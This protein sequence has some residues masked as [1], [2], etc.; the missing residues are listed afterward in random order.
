MHTIVGLGNPG[1]EYEE[2]RHNAG[3]ITL[4]GLVRAWNL[5]E[6]IPSSKSGGEVTEGLVEGKE[7][8]LFIP[9]TF[10]NV[11]GKAVSRFCQDP[12][13][14]ILVSDELDLPL[15][16]FR[17]SYG[18][19]SGGHNG[20]QSVIDA[21]GTK[22]FVRVRIGVSPTT[23][24]G[25]MKKPQKEKVADFVLKKFSKRESAK[26]TEVVEALTDAILM[27]VREGKEKAMQTYNR[28]Q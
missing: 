24:F 8:R 14:I 6:F 26:L 15:G 27:I 2:T 7:V 12:K 4:R 28:E 11:S 10:M 25:V 5:P 18:S 3:V 13:N 21:L 17:I 19:G 16:T 23:L 9:G 22:D 1:E 20:V